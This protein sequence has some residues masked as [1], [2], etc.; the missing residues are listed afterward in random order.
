MSV[1]GITELNGIMIGEYT[2]KLNRTGVSVIYFEDGAAGG[3]YKYGNATST[4]QADSLEASHTVSRIDA[5]VLSGGSAFGLDAGGGVMRWLKEK[6]KGFDVHGIIVPVVPTAAIFD[7]RFSKGTTPDCNMGYSACNA[8]SKEIHE[9]SAGA[10]T[11][12][13]VGKINGIENAMK[14]GVGTSYEKLHTGTSVGVYVVVNA[15]GDI[16]DEKRTIIAGARRQESLKEFVD[17]SKMMREGGVMHRTTGPSGNT[18]LCVVATN[19]GFDKISLI[20]IAKMASAGIARTISPSGSSFDGDLVFAVSVGEKNEF[21]DIVGEVS[22]YLVEKAIRRAVKNADGFGILP[23]Y[24]ELEN[25][26]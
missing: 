25:K 23:S 24:R 7:L 13:T 14:G 3:I 1:T 26:T 17:T 4:R 21:I 5:I 6:G 16:T 19:A 22:A 8:L 18:T 10:G 15:F 9:G 12:A 20:T 2:D 11:G